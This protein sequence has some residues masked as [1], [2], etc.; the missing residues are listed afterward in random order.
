M[1]AGELGF[2]YEMPATVD[3]DEVD[4]NGE[5]R[6]MGRRLPAQ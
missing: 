4:S 1:D 5:P 3:S 6:E 2:L